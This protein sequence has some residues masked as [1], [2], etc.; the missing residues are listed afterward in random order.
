MKITIGHLFY[1]LLNLY[2]ESGNVLALEKALNEQ[3]IETEIRN[4][5]IDNAD[6]NLEDIDFIY[7][8]TGTKNNQTLALEA[9]RKNKEQ[10]EKMVEE[11][12]FFL[13]TGNS[14]ELFGKYI[15]EQDKKIET[16][17]IFDYYTERQKERIVSECVFNC[18]FIKSE[19]L[20]FENADGITKSAQNSLF[21]VKIGAEGMEQEGYKQENILATYLLGPILARNPELLEY[22][23]K[24]LILSKD[25]EFEFK[26]FDFELEKKAHDKFLAKYE[27]KDK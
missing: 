10:L 16:L 23:C 20:G 15:L 6:W 8:G 24:K 7:I 1:D 5:S 13:I 22:I 11:K 2:G 14:I 27:N 12:K 3:G 18:D 4:L 26:E 21:T 17:G 19:I 9:L 25:D